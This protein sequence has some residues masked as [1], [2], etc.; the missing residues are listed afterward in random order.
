M[1]KAT[2]E[3]MALKHL[4]RWHKTNIE[5]ELMKARAF[6]AALIAQEEAE[7]EGLDDESLSLKGADKIGT[8]WRTTSGRLQ[9]Q[10]ED[11]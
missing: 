2:L 8:L 4:G 11:D 1:K 9:I 3:A 6:I 10:L 7:S 5:E